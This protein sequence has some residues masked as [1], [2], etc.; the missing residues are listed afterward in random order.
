MRNCIRNQHVFK[1]DSDIITETSLEEDKISDEKVF[2]STPPSSIKE[3]DEEECSE[4]DRHMKAAEPQCK[5][6]CVELG[7]SD[8][9][10][11]H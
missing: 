4:K 5:L 8:T 1:A 11:Y 2:I 9:D 7:E 6:L 10:V 3:E